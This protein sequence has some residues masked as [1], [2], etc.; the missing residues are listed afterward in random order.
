MGY[1]CEGKLIMVWRA[2]DDFVQN[3]NH[4]L[5]WWMD[6]IECPKNDGKKRLQK[7][8]YLVA[9]AKASKSKREGRK[10]E[11]Y[12]LST[13]LVCSIGTLLKV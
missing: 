1:A 3:D 7:S 11:K 8:R 2:Y 4:M 13:E 9:Q 6:E 12:Q 10:E 5:Y